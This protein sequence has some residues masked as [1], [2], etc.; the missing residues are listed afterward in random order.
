MGMSFFC[1]VARTTQKTVCLPTQE[2]K[3]DLSYLNVSSSRRLP[4][5]RNSQ[6]TFYNIS[7]IKT[8]ITA[9]QMSFIGEVVHSG[10]ICLAKQLLTAWCGNMS[11]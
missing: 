1:P 4:A 8:T 6:K 10:F 5:Q 2:Y 3:K 9:R 11:K 7:S